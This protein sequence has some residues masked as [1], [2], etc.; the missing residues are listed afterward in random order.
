MGSALHSSLLS[1]IPQ[2]ANHTVKLFAMLYI[3]FTIEHFFSPGDKVQ[4]TKCSLYKHECTNLSPTAYI[5]ILILLLCACNP[6]ANPRK[7]GE[8][9]IPEGFWPTNCAHL[10]SS[11]SVNDLDHLNIGVGK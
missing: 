3:H 11:K 1:F 2:S 9:L 6:S 5:K 8:K 10:A 7:D 4:M